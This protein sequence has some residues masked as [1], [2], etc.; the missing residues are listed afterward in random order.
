VVERGDQGGPPDRR[1]AAV[2]TGHAQILPIGRHPRESTTIM[3]YT[4][5]AFAG[6][7]RPAT[8]AKMAK[9]Q[10]LPVSWSPVRWR[11]QPPLISY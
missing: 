3:S 8:P 5:W 4:R 1:P 2:S 7:V 6:M 10:V 11:S 9:P